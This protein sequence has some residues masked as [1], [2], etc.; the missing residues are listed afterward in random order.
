MKKL[1]IIKCGAAGDVVRTTTL[2]HPYRDW[3]IDWLISPEN[4]QLLLND[5]VRALFD[6]PDQLP[7]SEYDLVINLEDDAA[8]VADVLPRIRYKRIFG[9]VMDGANTIGY[10]DDAA[11]WFDMGLISRYGLDRANELKYLNRRSYQEIIFDGLGLRFN[12]EPYVMPSPLPSSECHGD[13]AV[14]PTAGKRWPMK[15]WYYTGKLIETLSKK[16]RVTTLPVRPTMLD[17]IADIR[18]HKFVI[19][20]DSLPMHLA[21]GLVIPCL[22]VFPCTGPWE[23]HDYGLLTK[24]ESPKLA[25]YFFGRDYIEDAVS[26]I[27]FDA[28]Y[29]IVEGLL[30]KHNI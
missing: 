5:R 19:A 3:E 16:Y 27:P 12:G 7:A 1:L 15:N 21:I 14:A 23:I 24:V 29:S 25:Q 17:H 26:C 9:A 20:P 8:Y 30:K 28:V 6:S 11:G 4:R 2:L 13:I 22:S 18:N 10:T